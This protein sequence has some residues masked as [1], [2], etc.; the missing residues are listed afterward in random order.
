MPSGK[1]ALRLSKKERR[2]HIS[3]HTAV[4]LRLVNRSGSAINLRAVS[5]SRGNHY[6][7]S[8]TITEIG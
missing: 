1:G 3:G 8:L 7:A 5:G 4:R 2:I 6:S